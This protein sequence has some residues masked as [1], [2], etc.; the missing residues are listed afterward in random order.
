MKHSPLIFLNLT[1]SRESG[2][3]TVSGR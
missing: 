1:L 3:G 2:S